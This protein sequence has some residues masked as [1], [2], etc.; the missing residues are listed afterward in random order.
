[1]DFMLGT[2]MWIT[3]SWSP[4]GTEFAD[5]RCLPIQSN[6]ALYSLMGTTYGADIPSN[7][8]LPDLRPKD[9]DS[10]PIVNWNN[11]PRA[12]VTTVGI[13]PTRP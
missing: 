1:M 9:K 8:C 10:K 12:V 7:F 3:M 13:Y 6:A 4:Q 11:G 5:G 2:I